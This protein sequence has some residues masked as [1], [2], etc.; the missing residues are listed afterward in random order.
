MSAPQ[1]AKNVDIDFLRTELNLANTLLEKAVIS[2][3]PDHV[4]E[5]IKLAKN[6]QQTVQSF[7]ASMKLPNEE[8]DEL[9]TQLRAVADKLDLYLSEGD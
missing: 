1:S 7:L 3:N 4:R 8:K 9:K 2:G 6:A 5:C